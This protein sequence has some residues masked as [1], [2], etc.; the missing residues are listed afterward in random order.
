MPPSLL[1]ELSHA[2]SRLVA[3]LS[4]TKDSPP[5]STIQLFLRACE[6]RGHLVHAIVLLRKCPKASLLGAL[7]IPTGLADDHL[8]WNQILFTIADDTDITCTEAKDII[9][10]LISLLDRLVKNWLDV[11]SL[12][13][14]LPEFLDQQS[15]H[16]A[17]DWQAANRESAESLMR[18]L[19]WGEEN[20]GVV[21]VEHFT[22]ARNAVKKRKATA[23]TESM[24]KRKSER[25]PSE[26]PEASPPTV[27]REYAEKVSESSTT[28]QRKRRLYF[29]LS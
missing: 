18:L 13:V 10:V 22:K 15:G 7:L 19:L 4:N 8:D 11:Q 21:S 17:A 6:L 20:S 16:I 9:T 14:Y 5:I 12:N 23:T 3:D 24:E 2:P 27:K 29:T 28:P 25:K 26:V 1:E